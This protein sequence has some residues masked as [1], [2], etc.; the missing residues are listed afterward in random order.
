MKIGDPYITSKNF[1]EM[2]KSQDDLIKQLKEN[3]LIK[4]ENLLENNPADESAGKILIDD[5]TQKV[6]Q[7]YLNNVRKA[8]I[9]YIRSTIAFEFP[10]FSSLFTSRELTNQ[11]KKLIEEFTSPGFLYQEPIL[12]RKINENGEKE[13][14]LDLN[15]LFES[16]SIYI[17]SLDNDEKMNEFRQNAKENINTIMNSAFEYEPFS[18]ADK[19]LKE[20]IFDK[21]SSTDFLQRMRIE[22][23]YCEYFKEIRTT[24]KKISKLQGTKIVKSLIS[25]SQEYGHS[26]H[27]APS[28]HDKDTMYVGIEDYTK[29]VD[30]LDDSCKV[31]ERVYGKNESILPTPITIVSSTSKNKGMYGYFL[32]VKSESFAKG[33]II[34][35]NCI[36]LLKTTLLHELA[37]CRDAMGASPIMD[38]IGEVHTYRKNNGLIPITKKAEYLSEEFMKELLWD[39]NN[40]HKYSSYMD[41]I[42]IPIY[43][44]L[45]RNTKA[46]FNLQMFGKKEVSK[47]DI[48]VTEKYQNAIKSINKEVAKSSFESLLNSDNL[49]KN[50]FFKA[51]KESPQLREKMR[52]MWETNVEASGLAHIAVANI[53]NEEKNEIENI[54]LFKK[55]SIYQNHESKITFLSTEKRTN[56]ELITSEKNFFIN[57]LKRVN[58]NFLDDAKKYCTLIDS[59]EMEVEID[60]LMKSYGSITTEIEQDGSLLLA[61]EFDSIEV[62][63]IVNNLGKEDIPTSIAFF[64][65]QDIVITPINFKRG[66]SGIEEIYKKEGYDKKNETY[67]KSGR[68]IFARNT[69][70]LYYSLDEEKKEPD[71]K[72]KKT[73]GFLSR[74]ISLIK[75]SF[76]A[77]KI[78]AEVQYAS[79]AITP[80]KIEETVQMQMLEVEEKISQN[81]RQFSK[82]PDIVKKYLNNNPNVIKEI[83]NFGMDFNIRRDKIKCLAE[84]F[85]E[86]KNLM[87]SIFEKALNPNKTKIIENPIEV[88]VSNIAKCQS[89]LIDSITKNKNKTLEMIDEKS[90]I[91]EQKFSKNGSLKI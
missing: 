69:E 9:S 60:K 74:A 55:S 54:D 70:N 26:F 27:I 7:K 62:K 73:T 31:I 49:G 5:Q 21:K 75:T 90:K 39:S 3:P 18:T 78:E 8:K 37:H 48:V 30:L 22:N 16:K 45:M 85:T 1:T 13:V 11:A 53:K 12:E 82:D 91:I 32:N 61:K 41:K 34:G 6:V 10:A 36:S 59:Q 77:E 57:E 50:A 81:L 89:S 65:E 23:Q 29:A 87:E 25:L 67:L 71:V 58:E 84:N 24:F 51:M 63:N 83:L 68:E 86:E 43:K 19:F 56:P 20:R 2:L 44:E 79:N 17:A 47:E 28:I 14:Y 66:M 38:V 4:E 64:K 76:I 72:K 33:K 46:L 88:T 15:K 80:S 40:I 35:L 42:D 52:K